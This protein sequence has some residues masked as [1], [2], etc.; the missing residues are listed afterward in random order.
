[1]K[2]HSD[3]LTHELF[4]RLLT[5]TSPCPTSIPQ[6][7]CNIGLLNEVRDGSCNKAGILLGGHDSSAV[8]TKTSIESADIRVS[9]EKNLLYPIGMY[10]T[11]AL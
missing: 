7:G 3:W 10:V 2:L 8:G 1:M 4:Q 9:T 5:Y 6:S 11:A